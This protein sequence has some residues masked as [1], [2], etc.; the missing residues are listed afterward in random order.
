M[1]HVTFDG[2]G[3]VVQLPRGRWEAA[4]SAPARPAPS[5]AAP[6]DAPAPKRARVT[7][8]DLSA[9]E[10]TMLEQCAAV[11][12]R[13]DADG[14]SMEPI[15]GAPLDDTNRGHALLRR[16][17][18]AL[19]RLAARARLP[20]HLAGPHAIAEL[21]RMGWSPGEGLGAEGEG[22]V[23]PVAEEF[24]SQHS[25]SGLGSRGTRAARPSRIPE[26][27]GMGRP[28]TSRPS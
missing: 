9:A 22:R 17:A 14:P 10:R 1:L 13:A 24:S 19:A 6:A 16:C 21:R 18:R 15:P 3:D 23:Q 27:R 5:D 12:A 11:R 20:P 2:Y 4:A 8:N 7:E 25:R 28:S 26:S